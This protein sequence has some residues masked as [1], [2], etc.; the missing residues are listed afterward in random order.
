[1]SKRKLPENIL[2]GLR[3]LNE[4]AANELC[5]LG[6]RKRRMPRVTMSHERQ[7]ALWRRSEAKHRAAGRLKAA[8]TAAR[9]AAYH[10]TQCKA[11][12]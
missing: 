9:A 10:E 11:Q 6:K 12:V 4:F 3:A 8:D 7:A 2:A 1:M 5:P